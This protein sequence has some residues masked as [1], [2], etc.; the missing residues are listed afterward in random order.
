MSFIHKLLSIRKPCLRRQRREIAEALWQAIVLQAR[1]SYFYDQLGVSDSIDGRYNMICLHSFV[2]L[3]R[4]KQASPGNPEVQKLAQSLFDLSF[5]DM[6]RSLRQRGISDLKIGVRV[7]E[8][9]KTLYGRIA[10]FEAALR[11]SQP[12]DLEP[13]AAAILRN[14]Y[15]DLK[16]AE[17]LNRTADAR[18][19][20]LYLWQA[21]EL[22]DQ[23]TIATITQAR[24][25][26]FPKVQP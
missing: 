25:F 12:G 11:D 8:M 4:L 14:I 7:K 1:H 19:L 3:R 24:Q 9:A 13:L 16:P 5:K 23:Q 26:L 2:V 18:S 17:K 10:A 20:A 21:I 22:A 6:D 15:S